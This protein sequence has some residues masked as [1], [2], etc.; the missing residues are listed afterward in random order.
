METFIKFLEMYILRKYVY[1]GGQLHCG[2]VLTIIDVSLTV[3]S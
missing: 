2:E 3:V 1:G